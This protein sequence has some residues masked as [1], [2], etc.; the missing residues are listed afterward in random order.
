MMH[1]PISEFQFY[2]SPI[3][4]RKQVWG[5]CKDAAFQFYDSPIKSLRVAVPYV[6]KLPFQFYDSPIKRSSSNLG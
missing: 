3:K 4:S 5:R 6:A 2:D 1:N